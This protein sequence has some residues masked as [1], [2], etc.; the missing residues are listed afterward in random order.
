MVLYKY[1]CSH[2]QMAVYYVARVQH[3]DQCIFILKVVF[4]RQITIVVQNFTKCKVIMLPNHYEILTI[5]NIMI[6]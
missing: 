2:A 6:N 4:H 5:V 3:F 1:A